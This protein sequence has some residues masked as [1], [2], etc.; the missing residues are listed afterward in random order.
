MWAESPGRDQGSTFCF[1]LA[2]RED[3]SAARPVEDHA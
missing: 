1:T 2:L 3:Y